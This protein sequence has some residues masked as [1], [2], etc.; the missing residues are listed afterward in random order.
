MSKE[1]R[2]RLFFCTICSARVLILVILDK[3]GSVPYINFVLFWQLFMVA[4]LKVM[5]YNNMV[6]YVRGLQNHEQTGSKIK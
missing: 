5:C 1:A 3:I 6:C 4:Y 2:N